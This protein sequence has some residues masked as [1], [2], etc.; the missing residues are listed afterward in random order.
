[1]KKAEL[2]SIKLGENVPFKNNLKQQLSLI[3]LFSSNNARKLRSATVKKELPNCMNH[4]L[5]TSFPRL[6][7][8]K[9]NRFDKFT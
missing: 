1:M 5:L 6:L 9:W 2:M 3:L 7:S 4:N 8:L